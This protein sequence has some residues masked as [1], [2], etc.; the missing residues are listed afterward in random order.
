MLTDVRYAIRSFLKTPGFTATILITLALGIGANTAIFS[1]VQAVLL[2]PFPYDDAQ[3]ILR[4]RRGTSYPDFLDVRGSA[5][6][7]TAMAAFRPQL[8]DYSTGT[9]AERVEGALV[10][11]DAMRFFSARSLRGRLIAEGDDRTGRERSVVV[12]E[13]FWRN[14]LGSDPAVVGRRIM[15]NGV[16]YSVV[17]VTAAG[18]ELPATK[19]DI[20]AP[21]VPEAGREATS[22]GAHTLRAFARVAEG[23]STARAQSEMDA[24][25]A[26]LES[27]YPTTNRDVRFRLQPLADSVVGSVRPALLILLATVGFVLLI[28]CVNVANLLLARGAARNGELALRAA[29]G[30]SRTRIVRLLL[31]ES[32]VLSASG[33]ALGVVAGYV[34]TRAIVALAPEA[35]PRL[36][37]VSIDGYVLAF[38]AA[39]SFAAAV[40]FGV[41]PAW[42]G[43]SRSLADAAKGSSRATPRGA[44]WRA[45]LMVTETALAL[46]LLAGA[47]LLLRSFVA[48]ASLPLGFDASNLVTANLT[49]SGERYGSIPVR[50]QLFNELEERLR[51]V[52]GVRGVVLTTDLPIGGS[53]LFHNL[54]FE[55]RPMTAGTEPEVYY[56]GINAAYF[57]VLGIPLRRGRAFTASDRGGA[58]P[59]AVVNEAFVREYYPNDEP[60]GKRVRWVSGDGSWITIVGVASDV[61]ALSLDRSEVPAVYVPYAQEGAAWRRWMDVAIKTSGDAPTVVPAV[62]AEL[63][64]LDPNVPLARVRSMDAVIAASVADRRFNLVLLGGF[65]VLALVLA[66][67]GT[68]GV[69]SFLVVQRT[70]EIGVR[71]AL[72]ARPAHV[73]RLVVGRGAVLALAGI[74]VGVLAAL[75][76]ARP[77]EPMLFSVARTDLAT[78]AGAATVLLFS[79]LLAA[80]IPARRAMRVDPLSAL[81]SE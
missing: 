73:L 20:F 24:L 35:T 74:T 56:R 2:R 4:V 25:A 38:A 15:L 46:V 8:F 3:Q 62:R 43:A 49:L 54:A 52:P 31:T 34:M 50:T 21:F 19:A 14:R 23:T 10:A 72:G 26:A 40:V 11:D 58:V 76:A 36:A 33:G 60:L 45:V 41:V 27:Q 47:G 64:R 42:I 30:A 22:R 17:G 13:G 1:V 51:A 78:F 71:I 75:A 7:F 16:P 28:A 77:L 65:A 57:D 9:E 18:F 53:P 32:V 6:S 66:A 70:R 80:W 29:I 61:R 67:A 48:L 79:A 59:V 37:N 5:R 55:G 44:R 68:Y 39:A 81:R 69:M 63:R 12:S